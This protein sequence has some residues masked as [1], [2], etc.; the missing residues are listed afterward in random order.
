MR[1]GLLAAQPTG[2]RVG[3]RVVA[4]LRRVELRVRVP[5]RRVGERDRWPRSGRPRVRPLPTSVNTSVGA[6]PQTQ[7]INEEFGWEHG[8]DVDD[9]STPLIIDPC[10]RNDG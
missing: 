6:H 3:S 7:G 2:G 1:A 10:R 5:R 8:D 9:G 4:S